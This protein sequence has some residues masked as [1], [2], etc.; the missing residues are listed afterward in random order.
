MIR[1]IVLLLTFMLSL[2]NI[3]FSQTRITGY[4]YSDTTS[5]E[6]VNNCQVLLFKNGKRVAKA[7]TDKTGFYQ[8]RKPITLDGITMK[9]KKKE[10]SGFTITE[11]YSS[12]KEFSA[13]MYL[14]KFLR[15]SHDVFQGTTKVYRMSPSG[16]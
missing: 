2:L 1:Q 3:G 5:F 9:F 15:I 7:K 11:F 4:V 16:G 6:G 8:F 14:G 13:E 10:H 12:Q